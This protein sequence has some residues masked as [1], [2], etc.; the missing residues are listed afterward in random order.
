MLRNKI[1]DGLDSQLGI[2]L[3]VEYIDKVTSRMALGAQRTFRT[4]LHKITIGR[5]MIS[6]LNYWVDVK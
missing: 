3:P 6:P 1:I 2:L 4:G 5:S